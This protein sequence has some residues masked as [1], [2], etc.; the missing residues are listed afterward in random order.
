M[1]AGATAK[2]Y[3]TNNQNGKYSVQITDAN[4]CKNTSTDLNFVGI[5]QNISNISIN[6]QPNPTSGLFSLNIE[7]LEGIAKVS[8]YD[9]AG[10]EIILQNKTS[11]FDYNI[12]DQPAGIYIVKVICGQ[13]TASLKLVKE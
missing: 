5:N 11:L 10:R 1:I 7:G 13:R 12:T 6:I 3:N 4:G 8:I 9:I 2:T